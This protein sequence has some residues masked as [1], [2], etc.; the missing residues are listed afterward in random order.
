MSKKRFIQAVII[1]SLPELS[2]IAQAIKY[3]EGL[4]DSLGHHGYGADKSIPNEGKDYYD[5]LTPRQRQWFTGFWQAFNYKQNRNGAAMRWAQLGELSD[6]DYKI[7]IEAAKKEGIKQL[8]QGQARKMAQGWLHEKRYNDYQAQN[9]NKK[10]QKN[11]VLNHLNNELN[12]IKKLY[13]SSKDEALLKQIEN[14]EQA[15]RDARV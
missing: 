8:A 12:A 14:L 9:Q 5:E 1:R 4:Y 6:D 2:K 3:A 11:H 7:I 13:E 10:A 15:M